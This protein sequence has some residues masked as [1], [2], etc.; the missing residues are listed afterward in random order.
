[1]LHPLLN[2][3]QLRHHPHKRPQ[4]RRVLTSLIS[5][6]HYR[7]TDPTTRRLVERNL[8]GSWC[9]GMTESLPGEEQRKADRKMT[10]TG[11]LV[12]SGTGW[13]SGMGRRRDH[14]Q[15]GVASPGGIGGVLGSPSSGHGFRGEGNASTLSVDA[16]AR[17]E[18]RTG[19]PKRSASGDSNGG[20]TALARQTS[21]SNTP[22]TNSVILERPEPTSDNASTAHYQ[23]FTSKLF[24]PGDGRHVA[25]PEV[26]AVGSRL[27]GLSCSPS[28]SMVELTGKRRRAPPPP[29]GSEGGA[30]RPRTPLL[31]GGSVE[32][33]PRME[34]ARSPVPGMRRPAPEP[35]SAFR[36][37]V[38]AELGPAVAPYARD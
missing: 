36:K 20:W 29:P 28:S 4:L 38:V 5:H 22:I 11:E 30:S 7:E 14:P 6:S 34:G 15:A 19:G 33:S 32:G 21:G 23:R 35:P 10:A 1:V 13:S 3:T 17:E 18:G 12:G 31:G 16:V 9:D 2:N 24:P 27:E 8:R 25:D 37:K 26:D